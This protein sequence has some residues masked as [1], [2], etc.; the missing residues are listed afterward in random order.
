MHALLLAA[1]AATAQAASPSETAACVAVEVSMSR[2]GSA[3]LDEGARMQLRRFFRGSPL[4]M[5]WPRHAFRDPRVRIAIVAP[6]GAMHGFD[7]N[8]RLTREREEAIR[9]RAAFF[10]EQW[11]IASDRVDLVELTD[12]ADRLERAGVRPSAERWR[13]GYVLL[14]YPRSI[15]PEGANPTNCYAVF[16]R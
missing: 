8:R 2:S 16:S 11:E 3:D 12:S 9:A 13:S 7:Q 5:E 6:Y 1:L 4:E 15:V 14:E 10:L